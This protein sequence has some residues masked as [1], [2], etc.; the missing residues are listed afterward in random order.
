M[1][2]PSDFAMMVSEDIKGKAD[3]L[4]RDMLRESSNQKRWRDNLIEIINKVND[5]IIGIN[6]EITDLDNKYAE[7]MPGFSPTESLRKRLEKAERFRYHAEK[8]L[9]EADRLIAMGEET[10][11]MKLSSFLRAAIEEHMRIKTSNGTP[12]SV[13]NMLWESLSGK[14]AYGN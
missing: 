11:D 13:D 3:M 7:I 12:D 9:A 2:D 8:R 4:T 6:Q 10:V 1:I 5:Q 14:W